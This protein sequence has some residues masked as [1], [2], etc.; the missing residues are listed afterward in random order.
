ML[1][2]GQKERRL[3]AICGPLF[4]NKRWRLNGNTAISHCALGGRSESHHART[5]G[6]SV[7]LLNGRMMRDRLI[8]H[9]IRQACETNW[10]PISNR[11]LCCIWRS[12]HIGGRQ[13]APCQT[14][15]AFPSVA[16]VHDFI[17]Q[18]VL[19]VLQQ[20]LETPYRWTMNHNLHRAPSR[21]T[22]WRGAQS[23]C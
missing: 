5:G 8:N 23:F 2:G 11:H 6:N 19:S 7:L 1:E 13:R 21:K 15:S 4:S 18:G 9:A 12:T 14:R 10:G 22:A 3:G 17:Y 16:S 20:Q